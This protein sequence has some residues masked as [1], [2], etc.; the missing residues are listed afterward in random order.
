VVIRAGE[1]FRRTITIK[2]MKV[3][4]INFL[5]IGALLLTSCSAIQSVQ[6]STSSSCPSLVQ[7]VKDFYTANDT[8]QLVPTQS[9]LTEDVIFVFWAEGI[10]GH[11]MGL[12]TA[13][14]KDQLV[15]FLVNP[16]LHFKAVGPDL[17]NFSMDHLVQA[18]NQIVFNLTPDRTHTNGRP[19]DPYAVTMVFS[20]CRIEIIKLIERVTWV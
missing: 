19:Y 1:V 18:G 16:G 6:A 14:G 15:P 5:I 12:N 13:I 7:V 10:N 17:P 2:L 8:H 9:Y 4:I 20:G 11:H 3:R